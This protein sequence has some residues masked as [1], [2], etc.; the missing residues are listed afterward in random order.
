MVNMDLSGLVVRLFGATSSPVLAS[1]R[2][3]D[4][5]ANSFLYV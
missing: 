4:C 5:K 1:H 2:R 3:G